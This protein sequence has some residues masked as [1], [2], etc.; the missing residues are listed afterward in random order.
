MRRLLFVAVIAAVG[1]IGPAPAMA[2][3]LGLPGPNGSNINATRVEKVGYWRRMYRRYGY[4]GPYA[5][6]PPPYGYYPPV[7]AYAYPPPVYGYQLPAPAYAYPPP[8]YGN[9]TPPPPADGNYPSAEGDYGTYPPAEGGDYGDYPA[10][11][12]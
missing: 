8:V 4:P 12:S 2:T 11:G 10:N 7:A 3:S 6:Y 1:W 9:Q 5:Y